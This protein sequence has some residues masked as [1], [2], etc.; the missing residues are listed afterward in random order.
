MNKIYK[1]WKSYKIRNMLYN[2]YAN[3]MNKVNVLIWYK[4]K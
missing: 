1:I 3:N 2:V 4:R